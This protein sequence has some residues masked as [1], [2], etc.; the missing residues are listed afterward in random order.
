MAQG[1]GGR[2]D[3]CGVGEQST[4]VE[5]VSD[6]EYCPAGDTCQRDRKLNRLSLYFKGRSSPQEVLCARRRLSGNVGR[7]SGK[8]RRSRL[9][10]RGQLLLT[11]NS[12]VRTALGEGNLDRR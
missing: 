3:G 6:E 5:G 8:G 1:G 2:G 7:I 11:W 4:D 9:E 10:S 12:R